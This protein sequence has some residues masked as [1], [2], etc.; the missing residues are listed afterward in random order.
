MLHDLEK[1]VWMNRGMEADSSSDDDDKGVLTTISSHDLHPPAHPSHTDIGTHISTNTSHAQPKKRGRPPQSVAG[2]SN[3]QQQ[4]HNKM[5][6]VQEFLSSLPE[7]QVQTAIAK[8]FEQ[9]TEGEVPAYQSGSTLELGRAEL[10]VLKFIANRS[11]LAP[12][13]T[14]VTWP[15]KKEKIASCAAHLGLWVVACRLSEMYLS[16]TPDWLV[17]AAR[18]YY[19]QRRRTADNINSCGEGGEGE[20]E[21]QPQPQPHAMHDPS[22]IQSQQL[23]VEIGQREAAMRQ[24]GAV[25]A[26]AVHDL[27]ALSSHL[28]LHYNDVLLPVERD[29]LDSFVSAF[30]QS[31]SH[32][33]ASCPPNHTHHQTHTPAPCA[34]DTTTTNSGTNSGRNGEAG[35]QGGYRGAPQRF[36]YHVYEQ[37]V[38]AHL[39]VTVMGTRL[40]DLNAQ[41]G[42]DAL[43]HLQVAAENWV[44]ETIQHARNEHINVFDH[45]RLSLR[46]RQDEARRRCGIRPTPHPSDSQPCPP[47][48]A[49]LLDVCA[50]CI[51]RTHTRE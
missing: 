39:K 28:L 16:N 13:C 50:S 45:V 36:P 20:G 5:T 21:V 18:T 42:L 40:P 27:L 8:L 43:W 33:A 24:M 14:K 38:I 7:A 9:D 22:H 30:S 35:E 31:S 10:G 1:E 25:S 15:L 48:M 11:L 44:H 19:N 32:A 46:A 47:A 12:E 51:N 6:T 23:M 17:N 49:S 3:Q 41:P 29:H 4:Q 26:S 34:H 2:R 37:C